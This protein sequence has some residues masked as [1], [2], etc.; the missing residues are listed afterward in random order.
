MLCFPFARSKLELP[1]GISKEFEEATKVITRFQVGP[2]DKTLKAYSSPLNSKPAL[3]FSGGVD[4]MAALAIMPPETICFFL[5]REIKGKSL[6]NKE[7]PLRTCS[8]LKKI[9][10]SVHEMLSDLEYV[11][12]PVGFPVDVANSAP[13]ILMAKK[14][15][16]DSIAFGTIMESAYGIGGKE[17]RDYIN[18]N[19]NKLWGKLFKSAGI[20]FN[21]CVA[22]LSEVG[23]SIIVS[24]HPLGKLSQ[25]CIRGKWQK[26]CMNCWKCFRKYLL[27][28]TINN[29][30]I[31]NYEL[32]RLFKI[33]EVVHYLRGFPISHENV[34]TYITS[35]YSGEHNIMNILKKRVR[36]DGMKL[37]WL[38]NW[39]CES[40]VII[41][42]KYLQS[43]QMNIEKHI[44]VMGQDMINNMK[45]W[46]MHEMLE[47]RAYMKIHE[48]LNELIN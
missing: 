36:G 37:R 14:E 18:S 23:T 39:N 7:A 3:A 43:I 31:T 48:D 24:R 38:E 28:K 6:Y 41:Y 20:P 30:E 44:D 4:S 8:E 45:Q 25:S 35:R 16:I 47:D 5:N 15:K 10:Y 46:N 19:H 33:K 1:I 9:G 11:R 13:A 27:E 26:P 2:I 34:L 32:D 40:S 22:G 21:L 29:E 42:P 12:K 17:Y